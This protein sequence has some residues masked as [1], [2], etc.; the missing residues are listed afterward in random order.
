MQSILEPAATLCNILANANILYV[1]CRDPQARIPIT[2]LVLQVVANIFW[3]SFACF[4]QDWYLFTTAMFS[5]NMQTVS[6]VLRH[7]SSLLYI[8]RHVLPTDADE[9]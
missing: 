7:Y 4:Q 1:L 5:L 8:R 2:A 6:C 9:T 3:V